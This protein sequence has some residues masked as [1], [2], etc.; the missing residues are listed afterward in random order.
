[1]DKSLEEIVK[2]VD[3]FIESRKYRMTYEES[4]QFLKDNYEEL[5]KIG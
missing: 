5:K 1:M 3:E 2:F 4:L